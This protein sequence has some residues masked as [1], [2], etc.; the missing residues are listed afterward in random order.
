MKK[1]AFVD[2]DGTLVKGLTQQI[3]GEK[4][5][6]EKILSMAQIFQMSFW[7]VLYKMGLIKSSL[8]IRKNIYASFKSRSKRDIDAIIAET[9]A[10]V[11]NSLICNKMRDVIRTH[12]AN[13]ELVFAISGSLVDL[14]KP[15]CDEF[16][17]NNVFAT[18]LLFKDDRYTGTWEGDIW[19]GESKSKL[20]NSLS[21]KYGISLTESFAY[22]DNCQDLPMLK[23]VG[24]PVAVNPDAALKKIACESNWPI[25]EG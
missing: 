9:A 6:E 3:L 18:Q 4:L 19:E 15:I 17:I 2:V 11:A 1:A 14:I 25:I 5:K 24:H 21:G 7:F 22:A 13:G 8:S 10:K 12:Q 23:M 16:K 20:I